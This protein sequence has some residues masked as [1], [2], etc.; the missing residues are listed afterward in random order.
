MALTPGTKLGPYEILSQIGAG[1][2]GEVYKGRDTRL[3]RLVAVKTLPAHLAERPELRERF[4]REAHAIANLKHAHICV[5]YDIGSQELE[6]EGVTPDV[7]PP[8]RRPEEPARGRR[9]TV[10]YLVMEYLE[11]E[12]LAERLKKGPLPLDQTLQYATELSDAL[13]TAHRK[14][15]THRD[16]KP[17]NIM[18]TR[19][20]GMTGAKV[21]DFGL[22]KLKQEVVKATLAPSEMP[23]APG[24]L[25]EHG[26]LLGTLQYMAP[27]QIESRD[28][29]GR[30]D[31]FALGA[32][33]YEMATGK[34]A[35]DGQS[36]AS[37]IAKVLEHDPPPISSADPPGK[38][39]PPALD[40]VV[41]RCLAKDRDQRWQTAYDLWQ[42]LKWIK[43]GGSQTGMQVLSGAEGP[44]S[45]PARR[46]LRERILAA[47]AAIAL[48]VAGTLAITQFRSV[49]PQQLETRFSVSTPPMAEPFNVAISP[50]GRQ[51]AFIAVGSGG[52][53]QLWVRPLDSLQAQPLP[54]TEGANRSPFWSPDSR[55]LGFFTADGKLK[56]VEVSG[57]PVQTLCLCDMGVTA[58]GTWN[59]DGVIVFAG[60]VGGRAGLYRVSEAGGEPTLI[61]EGRRGGWPFFLPDGRHFLYLDF[62]TQGIF[63]RSLD[64][65]ENTRLLNAISKA[66]YAPPGYLL[67][68]RE[69]TLMAQP[70]DAERIELTGEAFPLVEDVATVRGGG[71]TAFTVSTNGSL[72]Y[73]SGT[74]SGETRLAWFDRHGQQLGALGPPGEYRNPRL[75]PDGK[76]VAVDRVVSSNKD[77]WLL[78]V[79]QG[80]AS[81]FTFDPTDDR[82]PV[83][84]PDGSRIVFD[85]LREGLPSLYQRVSSGTGNEELLLQSGGSPRDWSPDG[86][87]IIF[88]QVAG[89]V[90][91]L[92][93]LP[94]AG[95]PRQAVREA[96]KPVAFLQT[97][98]AE[99]LANLSPDGHWIAYVSNESGRFEVYVQ[100]FPTPSGKWQVSTEGGTQPRW[101]RDGREMFFLAPD[102][103]L[104]AVPVRL[105]STFEAGAPAAL[106]EANII[107]A[108]A[109]VPGVGHQYDV[110]ADGQRF[111]LNLEPQETASTPLTV[112]LNWQAGLKK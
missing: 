19:M 50:D 82:Y 42:D 70:F 76:R 104:M 24:A 20:G 93:F 18:L 40:R 68:V 63:V 38:L 28:V 12:T 2:M 7:A 66:A 37:V 80:T 111:L 26:T 59:Q 55:F 86:G 34:R 14:G 98:F 36:Q 54:G 103:K 90:N 107:P 22:A 87:S 94:L 102:Q 106:F 30:A 108:G 3:E 57:G 110:T 73:R 101:R 27:E 92:W 44:V 47:V 100:S 84:S 60:T 5:L 112:V 85:S 52:R 9:Y 58:G 65:Q 61:A 48:L 96:R 105:A 17:S 99:S 95:D 13:D 10:H 91:D 72:V 49:P 33:V 29:D 8:S 35:F 6:A 23:T 74:G 69:G 25:T 51:L 43:E 31:I 16:I 71:S 109:G 81:R 15:F 1:G 88:T 97:Q 77:I 46:K 79:E 75:S 83:W 62:E 53:Q 41:K 21:L 45:L 56:K 4:K 89:I 39:S 32:V 64:S 67:F 11:G 78:E